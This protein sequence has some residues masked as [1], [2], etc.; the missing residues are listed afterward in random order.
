MD[1]NY[2]HHEPAR[3]WFIPIV[4]VGVFVYLWLKLNS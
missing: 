1:E 2:H 3:L 4:I